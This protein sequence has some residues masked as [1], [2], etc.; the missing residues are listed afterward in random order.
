MTV[1]EYFRSLD[2][3][4]FIKEYIYYCDYPKSAAKK[5]I[6]R[7]LLSKLDNFGESYK[8]SIDK[9]MNSASIKED[10]FIEDVVVTD[11]KARTATY[12]G[13]VQNSEYKVTVMAYG[14]DGSI[15]TYFLTIVTPEDGNDASPTPEKINKRNGLVGM[16][17]F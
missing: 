3:K 17:L 13:L 1:Q 12:P 5:N 4:E 9:I 6:L 14:T 8:K 2:R 10:T 11:C 15:K 7:N 16:R